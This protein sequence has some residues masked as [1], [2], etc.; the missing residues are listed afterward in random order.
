MKVGAALRRNLDEEKRES[1][2]RTLLIRVA[3]AVLGLLLLIGGVYWSWPASAGCEAGPFA[4]YCDGPIREDG[5]WDRCF[6]SQPQAT[7]GGSGQVTGII[8]SVGRCYPI[9]PAA[10][11]PTPIGQPQYHIY[12]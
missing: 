12:P 5:S 11:P 2:Q 6:N 7:F 10:F 3:V 9:D 1:D 8:P 4:Q